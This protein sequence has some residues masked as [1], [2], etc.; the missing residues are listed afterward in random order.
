[1]ERM[2]IELAGESPPVRFL[3][4][5]KADATKDQ[6]K[7]IDRCS[8]ALFQDTEDDDAWGQHGGTKDD[9]FIYDSSGLLH[10]FLP[11]GGDVSTNLATDGGYD[12]LKAAILAAP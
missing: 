11:A 9:I 3:S 12:A 1:M 4:I 6:G 2:R 5:N 7:L 8:F 10:A